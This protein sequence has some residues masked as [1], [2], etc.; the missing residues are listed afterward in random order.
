MKKNKRNL[1]AAIICIAVFFAALCPGLYLAKDRILIEA[2]VIKYEYKYK[3]DE[4]I[5][6]L[7]NLAYYLSNSINAE[8]RCKYFKILIDSEELGDA[9]LTKNMKQL[10]QTYN[11]DM[12]SKDFLLSIYLYDLLYEKEF[13][14][15]LSEFKTYFPAFSETSIRTVFF[16]GLCQLYS[17][18]NDINVYYTFMEG[19]SQMSKE[20]DNPYIREECEMILDV[21]KDYLAS[22]DADLEV[23]EY[24]GQYYSEVLEKT[25]NSQ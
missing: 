6:N 16:G 25:D 5:E 2:N 22:E 19:Y 18:E 1:V 9:F 23:P 14:K 11:F 7:E 8:K 13:E 15:Y 4:S 24:T 10:M 20:S 12:T 21:V 17:T 3:K